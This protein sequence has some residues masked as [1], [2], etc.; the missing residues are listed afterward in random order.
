MHLV[1]DTVDQSNSKIIL[2]MDKGYETVEQLT[3][4]HWSSWEQES[5][6]GERPSGKQESD[7]GKEAEVDK[8]R[9][10]IPAASSLCVIEFDHSARS[11][12]L[13]F[14]VLSI[15]YCRM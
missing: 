4:G 6:G 2:E 10:T 13:S 14:T 7:V 1:T 8:E 9:Q 11:D 3:R 12:S 15:R 5:D